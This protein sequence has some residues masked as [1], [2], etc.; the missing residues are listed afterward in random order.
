MTAP[1]NIHRL[2]RLLAEAT[3][4]PWAHSGFGRLHDGIASLGEMHSRQNGALVAELRNAVPALLA[5]AWAAERIEIYDDEVAGFTE[6]HEALAALCFEEMR[7]PAEIVERVRATRA[8]DVFGFK[9]EVLVPRL[10]FAE[11]REWL[12][13]EVTEES[14]SADPTDRAPLLSEMHDYMSFAIEKVLYHRGI[15]AQRSVEKF[16]EWVWL[17]GDEPVD[18]GYTNY[19]APILRAICERYGWDWRSRVSAPSLEAFER[20]SEGQRC[21]PECREGCGP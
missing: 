15:S 3:P 4:G 9:A 20:M 16:E 1:L 7:T 13:P 17:L 8:A 11:A 5:V 6:L 14:W 10:P 19:G 21:H 2:E 18:A 12:K